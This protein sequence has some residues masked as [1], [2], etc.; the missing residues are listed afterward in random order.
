MHDVVSFW[1]GSVLYV[2]IGH[3]VHVLNDSQY[4]PMGQSSHSSSC[5]AI[6]PSL[7]GTHSVPPGI[8]E[9]RPVVLVS[10]LLHVVLPCSG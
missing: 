6:W 7:H 5:R 10:H 4:V 1:A 9:T 2:S 3:G 8:R